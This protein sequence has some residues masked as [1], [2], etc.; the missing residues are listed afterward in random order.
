MP[1]PGQVPPGVANT[2]SVSTAIERRAPRCRPGMSLAMIVMA[3]YAFRVF[4]VNLVF[5]FAGGYL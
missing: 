1:A 2:F 4:E 3:F 5:A